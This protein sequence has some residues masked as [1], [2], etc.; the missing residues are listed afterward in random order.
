MCEQKQ[1]KES[2]EVA[3]SSEKIKP[4]PKDEKKSRI[5]KK[6]EIISYFKYVLLHVGF[7]VI[8]LQEKSIWIIS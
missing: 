6:E 2:D 4:V 5:P 8:K 3:L 7:L 1:E